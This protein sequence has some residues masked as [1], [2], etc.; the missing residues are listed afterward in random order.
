[1]RLLR[2]ELLQEVLGVG[3]DVLGLVFRITCAL[4]PDAIEP[5]W[6]GSHNRAALFE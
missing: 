3:A 4:L 5:D 6:E 1:M 2:V